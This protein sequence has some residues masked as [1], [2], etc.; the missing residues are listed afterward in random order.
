MPEKVLNTLLKRY[1]V[2]SAIMTKHMH[3]A[4]APE[5]PGPNL[6]PVMQYGSELL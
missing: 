3:K 2:K 6:P 4:W 5:I 1:E